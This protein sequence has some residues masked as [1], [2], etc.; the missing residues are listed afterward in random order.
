MLHR[1]RHRQH[2]DQVRDVC[3][4]RPSLRGRDVLSGRLSLA[5]FAAS[6]AELDDEWTTATRLADELEI[7]H[8]FAWYRL[9]LILERLANDGLAEL[10][11]PGST[12]RRF[13]RARPLP[14]IEP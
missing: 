8:G 7:G 2:D 11:R 9:A 10:Y 4:G 13:R 3:E 14:G 12:V 5:I 1:P 6:S